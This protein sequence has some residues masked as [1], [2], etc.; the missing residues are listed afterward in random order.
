MQFRPGGGSGLFNYCIITS[1]TMM[2]T[3]SIINDIMKAHIRLYHRLFLYAYCRLRR[4]DISLS[5][6]VE[7][8]FSSSISSRSFGNSVSVSVNYCLKDGFSRIEVET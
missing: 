3:A 4:A 1:A 5:P 8:S 6:R 7:E 2:S